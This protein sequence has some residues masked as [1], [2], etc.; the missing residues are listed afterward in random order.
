ML[1]HTHTH[2]LRTQHAFESR[3]RSRS[4]FWCG[5]GC[6]VFIYIGGEG[7]Q[8]PPSP[9][10][11]FWAL[12]QKHGALMLALE[13]RFYG[14]SRP[15]ADMSDGSLKYLTS[16]QALADLARFH[17]M[18]SAYKPTVPDTTSSPPLR[19]AASAKRSKWISFGGSYPGA[20]ATWFKAKYPALVAGTVGSSAPVFPKYDFYEYAQVVGAALAHKPIGGSNGCWAAV[21]AGVAE[22]A[23]TGAAELASCVA[24]DEQAKAAACPL[25]AALRPCSPPRSRLDKATYFGN[26]FGLF[27]GSVQYNLEGRPPYVS[28][29]CTAIAKAGGA[30]RPLH[31]LA[32]AAA[33][34]SPNASDPKCVGSSFANDTVAPLANVTFSAPGCNLKCASDRQW[35]WQSCHEFGYFQTATASA[36][37]FEPFGHTLDI[38]TAGA[39]IC[40]AAFGFAHYSGP[41]ANAATLAAATE[42]GAR[43]VMVP[44]ITMPNGNM[45]P[46]HA[47]G[48]VNTSDAFYEAGGGKQR[49]G[50]GVSVVE[51]DGT[52]HCRDMYAPAAFEKLN[53]PISDTP[54]VEWAHAKIANDVARYLA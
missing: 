53:P 14:E 15:T 47:L 25:P 17:E 42:Y 37:P 41:A 35:I 45:D 12:A 40:E 27:Q 16:E 5:E 1:L 48:V 24:D 19:L 33:L 26:V 8:G 54:S 31:A 6:P 36:Q 49:V 7:P 2:R 21:R 13:H 3:N 22:L 29:V 32:A 4:R 20:L 10:L 50:A 28:D 38:S 52:A 23:L 39:A 30:L 18:I 46:W 44:N 51:L 43:Q 9:R 11:F 34:F